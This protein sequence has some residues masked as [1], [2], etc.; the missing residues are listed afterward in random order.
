MLPGRVYRSKVDLWFL[1]AVVGAAA[2]PLVAGGWLRAHDIHRGTLL[3]FG[4]GAVMTA[5]TLLFGFPMRYTLGTDRLHI[6]SGWLDWEVPY[7]DLRELRPTCSPL[8]GP[9]WSL[10]RVR[11]E[12]ADGSIILVSPD[13]RESFIEELITRCPHLPRPASHLIPPT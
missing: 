3:L 10:R 9:A 11:L 8:P 4:W 12:C 1:V 7:A 6:Q 2:A 5:A 13:D